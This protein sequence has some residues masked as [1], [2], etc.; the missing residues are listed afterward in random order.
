MWWKKRTPKEPEN[1]DAQLGD[2]CEAWLEGRW[3]EYLAAHGEPVPSWAWLNQVTHASERAVR[4]M[5]GVPAFRSDDWFKLRGCVAEALLKEAAEKGVS[6]G[7][8]QRA[9]LLPIE[10]ALFHDEGLHRFGDPQLIIRILAALRHPS[11]QPG[12]R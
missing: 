4:A 1:R 5:A 8:L 7:E 9:V 10:C 11:A 2:E 6:I 12:S 3:A